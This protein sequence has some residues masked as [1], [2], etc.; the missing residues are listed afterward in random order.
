ML[1]FLGLEEEAMRVVLGCILIGIP[2]GVQVGI[3]IAYGSRE[4]DQVTLGQKFFLAACILMG[5]VGLFAGAWPAIIL[6]FT[7][8]WKSLLIAL[9]LGATAGAIALF[10]TWPAGVQRRRRK[11][12]RTPVMQEVARFCLENDIVA[13]QCF[14]GHLRFFKELQDPD[15][16]AASLHKEQKETAAEA[17]AYQANWQKPE[18]ARSYEGKHVSVLRFADRDYPDVPDLDIFA[19]A[20]AQM[21]PGFRHVSHYHSVQYDTVSYSVNTRTTTH[22]ITVLWEDRL[23]FSQQA[24]RA[25]QKDWAKLGKADKPERADPTPKP[26]SWE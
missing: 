18:A 26:N 13:I 20:L 11:Y 10:I 3:S 15:Y 2:V 16:C 23:V 1:E 5:V 14:S 21:L 22:N 7:F 17:S 24:Y 8:Q 4:P 19:G 25:R 9:F 12:Q 6:F